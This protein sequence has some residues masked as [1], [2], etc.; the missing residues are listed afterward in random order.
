MRTTSLDLMTCMEEK[1]FTEEPSP[2]PVLEDEIKFFF[3]IVP[4][5]PGVYRFLDKSGYPLY[6]GKAKSLKKRL[7][8]YF[9]VS[10]RTKKVERLFEEAVFIDISLT[11]TE[12]ESLLHEQFLIKEY[13]PKFNVQFKDDKGYPWIKIEVKKSY[14]SAKSYLGK[15]LKDGNFYGPFPNGYAVRDA[16]KLIQKTFKLRNCSDSYFKNRS[17]PCLQHEIG[18]CSAPCVGLITKKEYLKDV[19]SAKLLLEGKSDELIN[20]FYREMDRYSAK[21]NYERAAIYR[22][23]ISALRDIQRSQSIAG[24][25][26]NKDAISVKFIKGKI[27][28]GVTSVNEGWVIGHK[29]FYQIDD[30]ENEDLL[31]SF[32]SQKYFSDM[33]CPDKIVLGKKID[34]KKIIETA[35]SKHHGKK[36]S[37]VTKLGKKDK[38]L[39]DLCLAN[40]EYILSKDKVNSLSPSR[41]NELSEVLRTDQ[42][43]KWIESYDISHHGGN[44]A[45]AGCVVYSEKGKEKNYYRSYNISKENAGNDIGSMLEVIERRFSTSSKK[46]LPDLMIIDGGETHLK[47]VLTKL[48][49]LNRNSINVISISKGVRRK[50]AFDNI[51]LRGGIIIDVNRN[52]SFSNFIQEIRDETHRF[53]ITLQ[54]RKARRSTIKSSIDSLSGVGKVRKKSLIRYFGSIEQ[55]KRA[56]IEDLTEVSGIGLNTAKSIFEELHN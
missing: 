44:H 36:V 8:S 54:Q 53:A 7:M 22:D 2:I 23:R 55:L 10:A 45:V 3:N 26:D 25:T 39:M 34:N 29:N 56:S 11:N 51:H 28:I 6:I 46:R 31:E 35:L 9:R 30:Y 32:I 1:I 5:K 52:P 13:K 33:R 38:G 41:L 27:R 50:S 40:T 18:R 16:L 24:F 42:S 43:I 19:D 48:N 15:N 21:K 17:R 12:L 47:Q 49:K 37:I 4:N 20:D 14:P